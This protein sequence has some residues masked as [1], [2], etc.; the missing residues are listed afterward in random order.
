MNDEAVNL[1][2]SK[3]VIE[4][5]GIEDMFIYHMNKFKFLLI[6]LQNNYKFNLADIVHTRDNIKIYV[7]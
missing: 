3:R 7:S 2:K 4:L 5:R 1:V 6:K